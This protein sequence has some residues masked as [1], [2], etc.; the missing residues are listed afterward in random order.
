MWNRLRRLWNATR[1]VL[2]VRGLLQWLGL[3]KH[4][5][6]LTTLLLSAALG[7]WAYIRG[8]PSPIIALIGIGSFSLLTLIAAIAM[9]VLSSSNREQEPADDGALGT[10]TSCLSLEVPK[11]I[12]SHIPLSLHIRNCGSRFVRGIRFEPIESRHGLKLWLNGITNLAPGERVPLGFRV[13]ENGEYLG[14]VN[15]VVN[16]F[17]GGTS[18]TDQPPYPITI[19]FLDGSVERTEQH[20]IEGHPL[21]KGGARL[22]IYPVVDEKQKHKKAKEAI[23]KLLEQIAK[24]ELDAYKGSNSIEYDRLYQQIEQIK[25]SVRE[26][27]TKYLDSSLESRF[28]AV[29]VLDV[30]LDEATKMHFIMREQGSFWTMYQQL[31]GWRACLVSI[32]QELNR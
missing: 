26:I 12:H 10:N 28:L 21:P 20:I 8:L 25:R 16:F 27:A 13:G 2:A 1:Q 30:Q 32:L 7:K 18:S 3:W 15:H 23:G 19:R 22:E 4:I 6:I 24:C 9:N 14:V 11:E 29:N 31:K 17:E 5:P